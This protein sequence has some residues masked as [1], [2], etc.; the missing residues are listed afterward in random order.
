MIES[1]LNSPKNEVQV[2]SPIHGVVGN[3]VS[4]R[5]NTQGMEPSGGDQ[6]E[7]QRLDSRNK[8]LA[9]QPSSVRQCSSC[10]VHN[11]GSSGQLK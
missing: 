7:P 6:R 11:M 8:E 3:E 4:K 5:V 9:E 10:P 2:I 1:C